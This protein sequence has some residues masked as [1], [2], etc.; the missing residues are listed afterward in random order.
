MLT[1]CWSVAVNLNK[2]QS[3]YILPTKTYLPYLQICLAS[4]ILATS[5]L[6]LDDNTDA[7]LTFTVIGDWGLTGNEMQKTV[8]SAMADWVEQNGASFVISSGD[9]FYEQ[10]VASVN[11]PQ[12][13]TAWR[14]VSIAIYDNV[15]LYAHCC[16]KSCVIQNT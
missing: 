13:D 3:F 9:N 1:K 2:D 5:T 10:G 4:A 12:F 11:D 6:A 8:A 7:I 16:W 14:D 15:R